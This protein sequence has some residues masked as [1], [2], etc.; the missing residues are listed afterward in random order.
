[1]GG[2]K[3]K[4]LFVGSGET[5]E[6]C[7]QVAVEL[8]VDAEFRTEVRHEQLAAFYREI[9]LFVLPSYFEG[10]GCVYLE[11]WACGV[12]FI[13]C[14]GQGIDDMIYPED[15]KLWLAKPKDADNLAEKIRYYIATRPE[16]RLTGE[17]EIN[18]LVAGFLDY[19][20]HDE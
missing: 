16:Q 20:A 17:I 19:L 4:I 13:G 15:R 7:R 18:H 9:D 14:E 6:R 12:P 1:M 2:R 3:I 8:G 11:A 5:M 10:F